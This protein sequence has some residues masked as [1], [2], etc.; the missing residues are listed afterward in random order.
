MPLER[1]H[2]EAAG[3][4]EGEGGYMDA[5]KKVANVYSLYLNVPWPLPNVWLG[6][7]AEDQR[8]ANERVPDLLDTPAAVRFVSAEPLL[9]PIDLM[10]INRP[11]PLGS[12]SALLCEADQRSWLDWIIVGGESGPGA[13]PIPPG[14]GTL[15]PRSMRGRRCRV[16]LQAMG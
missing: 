9:G 2:I 10:V 4:M 7:S 16:S 15:D 13:R 14:L 11:A 6:V 1:I 3:H 12:M 8:R 5:L